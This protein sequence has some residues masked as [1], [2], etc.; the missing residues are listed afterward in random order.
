MCIS[1]QKHVYQNT[2][3]HPHLHIAL[4]RIPVLYFEQKEGDTVLDNPYSLLSRLQREVHAACDA[5]P[6]KFASLPE[7]KS[8]RDS[9]VQTLHIQLP[10]LPMP[11]VHET[12]VLARVEETDE[13]IEILDIPMDGGVFASAILHM[14]A[15]IDR[16]CPAVLVCP[17]YGQRKQDPELTDICRT[18]VRRGIIAICADYTGTGNAANRPDHG[19][20][21]NNHAAA[22]MLL[23]KSD[24]GLRVE[25]NRALLAFLQLRPEVDNARIGITGLCQGSIVS[26]YTIATTEGFAAAALLCGLTTY[27]AIACEY[28]NREGGWSGT[29]PYL[30]GLLRY[31][32]AQHLVSCFAPRPLLVINN[33]V[34]R[35][36]PLSGF[37]KAR[38]LVEHVYGLYDAPAPTFRLLP[39]AHAFAEPQNS[40]I[41]DFMA[42]AL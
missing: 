12:H 38:A 39:C 10:V 28:M 27:E 31:A 16:P 18:L 15:H 8:Y 5:L 11:D 21:I 41:A 25:I 7:W 4:F 34:D 40:V 42:S 35:H 36:W 9:I 24:L 14:P 32:D 1:V 20:D 29:S 30:H 2:H 33:I 13:T 23:G 17:G 3:M 26:W 22:A 37:G 19:T 6:Q